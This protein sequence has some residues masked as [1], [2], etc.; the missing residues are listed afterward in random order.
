MKLISHR[1][2]TNG[3]KPELENSPDY[4]LAAIEL[5]VD[6]EVDIWYDGVS[7]VLGHSEPKYPVT[8]EFIDSIKDKAWF[9]CKNLAALDF[10]VNKQDDSYKYFWHQND[11]YR[12]TS[13]G[14][15]WAYPGVLVSKNVIIVD[16]SEDY[17]YSEQEVYGVCV[18]YVSGL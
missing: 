10:F 2:N 12:V 16:F 18:D 6:V 8:M 4:L 11:S 9:H 5:G 13:N 1:G 3:A 14:L 15:I 7:L 17:D